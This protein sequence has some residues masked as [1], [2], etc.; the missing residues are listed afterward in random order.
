MDITFKTPEDRVLSPYTGW[1]R[2]RWM[3]LAE[4]MI[5]ALQ[6]YV[7]PGKGGMALPNPVRWQ[8]AYLPDPENMQS[9]YWMEGFTRTRLL[10]AVYMT[11]TGRTTITTN[12]ST[13]DILDQFIEGL[14]SASDPQHPEYIGDRYGNRQ[15]IAETSAVAL[16]VY[17]ARELVWDKLTSAE[18]E[19]VSRWMLSA[20]GHSIPHNNWYLFVANT[21]CVLKAL[22]EEHDPAELENCL[23]EVKAF[24]AGHGWFLD[25][26]LNR[27]YSI[28]HYNAWGFHH[29]LPA[30]VL[31]NS[32][33]QGWKSYITDCL[34]EYLGNFK[35]FFAA[36]GAI[37]MWGR[38]WAYR[39][40]LTA[41]FLW[42]EL[43]GVS[44]LSP[45]E[46]R[47]LASGQMKYY[48][49]HDYFQ[50][51]MTPTMGL[52]GENLELI[53]PYSQYG[54]PYWGSAA[55]LSLLLPPSHPFWTAEEEALP[56]EREDFSVSLPEIGLIVNGNHRTGEVQMINHR[57]WHQ[58]EGS[59]TKYAKKYT[60]FAY[61]SHFGIDLRRD[62]NGYNCDNMFSVSP[63]GLKHS[64]RIVPVFIRMDE[65]YG[66][67]CHYPL[68]GF[69]FREEGDHSYSADEQVEVAEDRSVKI[70]TQIYVKDFCQI[71]VHVVENER[72]LAAV[73]EGGFALNY[74]EAI[75]EAIVEENLIAFWNG[76][77]GS[78]IRSLSGFTGPAD[79]AVLLENTENHH[80]LGG[81]SVTPTLIGKGLQP[82]QHVFISLSGTWFDSRGGYGERAGLVEGVQLSPGQVTVGFRDGSEYVFT[83]QHLM[84][85]ILLCRNSG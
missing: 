69:P 79:A 80:T 28:E 51:N 70:T 42:G 14:L 50:E 52:V 63:D 20:T 47:R 15:Y 18:R 17:L 67:S 3:E 77:R 16:A 1:D 36:N 12:G 19:Q 40:A 9:F 82:G 25:G 29:F 53:E 59:Q 44:P 64:Q 83:L 41:P 31:M 37:P 62:E 45:G 13:V 4:R 39:P 84:D 60:N 27:G 65:N 32:V 7:T 43:L 2:A 71:R 10:L 78:F 58:K 81:P 22:G 73:R 57:A 48:L 46:S 6:P 35:L 68:S 49:E 75:P 66:A 5:A 33:S 23:A 72:E 56:V 24:Y 76:E 21:H 85:R 30:F 26:D 74:A 61:S 11:G 38:S 8:D 55:F 54:S 34:V